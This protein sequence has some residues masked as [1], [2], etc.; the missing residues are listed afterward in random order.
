MLLSQTQNIVSSHSKLQQIEY[1]KE[2]I[3]IDHL[4]NAIVEVIVIIK[5]AF[6]PLFKLQI[7]I[8][9]LLFI[10]LLHVIKGTYL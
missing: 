9:Y 3:Q 2:G 4:H 7:H 1:A 6:A 10:N 8:Y 5:Q